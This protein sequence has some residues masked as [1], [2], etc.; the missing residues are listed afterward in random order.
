MFYDLIYSCVRILPNG[1][2]RLNYIIDGENYANMILITKNAILPKSWC[3]SGGV[4]GLGSNVQ[5]DDIKTP[6]F[7]CDIRVMFP[8]LLFEYV[9]S[10]LFYFDWSAPE[11]GDLL[12]KSDY[13]DN[14]C[15]YNFQ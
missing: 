10:P 15:P 13:S 4:H 14:P 7:V 9:F 6:I 12:P 2:Q 1:E 3:K 8:E 11:T 5:N